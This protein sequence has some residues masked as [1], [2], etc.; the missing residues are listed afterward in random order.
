MMICLFVCLFI[1]LFIYYL[2]VC[3]IYL[4]IYVFIYSFLSVFVIIVLF[5]SRPRNN[6]DYILKFIFNLVE[7]TALTLYGL[8]KRT[9][10]D[11]NIFEPIFTLMRSLFPIQ[12]KFSI[13]LSKSSFKMFISNDFI[14]VYV[15]CVSV[16]L[17]KL[18]FDSLQLIVE[19][20][21]SE[22]KIIPFDIYFTIV[23]PYR[24]VLSNLNKHFNFLSIYIYV[25][26]LL[27]RR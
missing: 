1:C 2:F 23:K 7:L 4:F 16:F 19:K 11:L 26:F 18:G 17:E 14:T 6:P 27:L 15:K 3:F 21:I 5:S 10:I 24:M 9:D 8:V 12:S 20:Y 13:C 25:M 22:K